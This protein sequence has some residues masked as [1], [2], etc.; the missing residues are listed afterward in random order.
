MASKSQDLFLTIRSEG[1]ILPPDLLQRIVA[2]DHELDGLKADDYHLPKGEKINEATSRAWNRLLGVWASF[3]AAADKLAD[4][5]PGTSVARERWLQPFFQELGY[6]RLLT[7]KAIEIDGRSYAISHGWNRT[8]IHLVGC[9]VDLDRSSQRVSGASRSSPHS[10]LQE[11]LNRSTSHLW[12]FVTNGLQMRILRNNASLTRQAF[13]EFDLEAMMLGENYADFVLLWL[14]C[15]QS[16]VEAENPHDCWLEKW[17]QA[18]KERGVRALDHLRR[19]V[20]LAILALGRGFLSCPSNRQLRDHLRTASLDPQDYYRQLLRLVYRLLFLFAAEDRGLLLLPGE[21]HTPARARY[22]SYYSTS[23]LRR[24]A[25]RRTGTRHTDLFAALRVV[26]IK[27]S[28]DAGYAELALP[29]LGGF[30]FSNSALPDLEA[31]DITNFELSEAIRALAVTVSNGVRR[32]VDYKNLGA[33]E[34]GSVYESLLELHPQVNLDAATF[35]LSVASGHERRT[36][37]SYY[38]PTSLIDCLL[39]SALDPVLDDAA[40]KPEAERAILALKVVDPACGSGHFLI[41]AAHRLAKRLAS[42]RTGDE[43]PSPEF[44]RTALRDVIGHCIYGVDINP[45]AVELCKVNLWM[46]ALEPGRPLSFL[47]HHIQCGNALLGTTPALLAEGI[48]DTAYIPLEGDDREA[49]SKWKKVNKAERAS[50]AKNQARF[51]FDAP[52]MKL[53]K[54]AE[55]ILA[56]DNLGDESIERIHEKE[57]L[58]AE[59]VHSGDYLDDRFLADAWCAAFVWKK[60]SL[61]DYPITEDI[62]RQIELNPTAFHNDKRAMTVEV[63]RLA[64]QYQ[65]VHWHLNFPGVFRPVPPTDEAGNKVTGWDGGFDVVLG[66]PPWERVKL[67]EREWFAARR[68]DITAAPNAAARRRMIAALE[69]EDRSLLAAFREDLR[70]AD[71]ESYLL[72]NSGRFPLCG[73]GDINTYAVFAETNRSLLGPGGR[74]GCIVP[75]GIATDNTTKEFFGDLINTNTLI[76][77]FDFENAVGLFEGVGHG[78]FKFC[79]LTL[80][81][82]SQ[83]TA[84]T[85]DFFFFAHHTSDLEDQNRHFTLTAEDITLINPNTRTC[86]IFRSKRD[87]EITKAIYRRV[88][89]LIKEGPPE[90]NPWHVKFSTMFHMSNDSHLF[91]TQEQLE[92]QGFELHGNILETSSEKYL[93]LYEAKMMHHFTHRFGDYAMRP[94][95]S[96]DTELPRISA[97]KLQD[98]NYAVQPRYWVKEWEVIKSISDVPRE[99]IQAVDQRL[100]DLARQVIAAWF[101]GHALATGRESA[102]DWLLLQNVLNVWDAMET[103]V[104]HRYAAMALHSEYPLDES[105]F[106]C[107]PSDDEDYLAAGEHLIRKRMPKWLVGFRKTARSGDV[108]TMIAA[109]LPVAAI[110]DKIPLLFTRSSPLL[111]IVNL[112]SFV[113]DYIT[114]QKVG[115]TDLSHFYVQQLAVLPESAYGASETNTIFELCGELIHTDFALLDLARANGIVH[116]PFRWSD[117][118]RFLLRCQLD[119]LY[120]HLYGIGRRDVEYIMDTFPIV[121]RKDEQQF[122]EYRTKRVILEIFDAMAE[123]E[124]IGAPYQTRLDPPPAD[125][126]V[127]HP[128][129]EQ[130]VALPSLRT[131]VA[132]LSQFAAAA[133]ATPDLVA[134]EHLALFALIDVIRAFNGSAKPADVRAAAIL[135][136]NPAMALAFL[137]QP[138]AKQWVRVIGPQARPLPANVVSIAQFQKNATDLP[139]SNAMSQL[140]GS[141]AL[142]TGADRWIAGDNFPVSSGQDWV[143]G[144]AAIAVE[145]VSTVLAA[146]IEER[147]TAFLGSVADG[148]ASRAV[149]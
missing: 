56:V 16:R 42:A 95:G 44:T 117:D 48:P 144:R 79:L 76:S 26:M 12:G 148:T 115:G 29:A 135:V 94:E 55:G 134:P 38:T 101:A 52:W 69:T 91:R 110:N 24:L 107:C 71:G 142:Q 32:P 34:L 127:A 123:A 113:L 72:R 105:D 81:G 13:V 6:G 25:E 108:R 77:L 63:Q 31:C 66:N 58:Y 149:S 40:R 10:L 45:M 104:Q 118:R 57:R 36:T 7:T 21:P 30:L 15:H 67:Q 75:S 116:A 125:P 35:E 84:S 33:E 47:E 131:T 74:V 138:Q 73:K 129:I 133:W 103:V 122:E 112:S 60:T 64:Q 28:T 128:A 120:F 70:R 146:E 14:L 143:T 3:R 17:S 136:R 96:L 106:D 139:W 92:S 37:G 102:G 111:L 141:G 4:T 51:D 41:A 39:D 140:T 53:G 145:L 50:R 90:E 114:R 130:P 119:A 2:G 68:P 98:P 18:W 8:P 59:A 82:S 85:P 78:R 93:P 9:H 83:P 61:T 99:L 109:A 19:G 88:P 147:L 87:A 89:V 46:E 62:F 43:E 1:A 97:E 27:L 54:V 86:P 121:R 11:T 137:D 5:D 126:R 100:E 23:R 80:A 49:C 20:E 65:F 22:L 124:R 132:H